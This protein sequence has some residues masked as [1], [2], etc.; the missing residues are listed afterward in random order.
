M[1]A[2]H[3]PVL[4]E[5]E[6]L[7]ETAEAEPEPGSEETEEKAARAEQQQLMEAAMNMM[8]S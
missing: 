4:P 3:L 8:I 2:T 1:E 7:E 5:R 6:A